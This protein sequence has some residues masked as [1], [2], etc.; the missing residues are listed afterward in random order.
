VDRALR[1]IPGLA[2]IGLALVLPGLR[3]PDGQL[4]SISWMLVVAG[5]GLAAAG[6]GYR[7]AWQQFSQLLALALVGHASALALIDAPNYEVLQHFRTWPELLSTPRGLL[8]LVPLS[9]ILLMARIVWRSWAAIRSRFQQLVSA[10]S[11]LLLIGLT[12]FAAAYGTWDVARY[13]GEVILASC[14][15]VANLAN[16][17]LVAAAIPERFLDRAAAW[18]RSRL[19]TA[20]QEKPRAVTLDRLLPWLVALGVTAVS[21]AISGLVLERT[22]HIPDSV[23]YLFQAKYFSLGKLFL[24]APPDVAA[25]EL[26]KLYTDG[27]RWWNYGFPAWPLVLSIGVRLGAAWLVNPILGGITILLTHGLLTRL[28]Q[29]PFAHAVVLLLAVSPWFLFMSASFMPH[30]LSVAWVLVGLLALHQAKTSGQA[31]WALL[32]G[33]SVGALLLN[34]PLEAVLIALALGAWILTFNH[35][36]LIARTLAGAG[37]GGLL[38]GGWIFPYNTALTGDPLVTPHQTWSDAL[39]YRGADRLGFGPD[40]GNLG[41]VNVDPFPGHGPVDVVV[42]AW[43]NLYNANI[44]LFGWSFGSLGFVGL[45]LLWRRWTRADW[46]FVVILIVI[47]AGHSVYWFSGGPDFGARYWY[48][49]LIPAVVL[50][51]RGIQEVQRRWEGGLGNPG[52]ST[53][54][55]AFVTLACAVS[56]VNFLPWRSL[57]KYHNYRGMNTALARLAANCDFGHALVFVEN[58]NPEDYASAFV[59]NPPALDLSDPIYVRDLGP[60]KRAAVAEHFPGRSIWVISGSSSAGEPLRVSA[61]PTTASGSPCLSSND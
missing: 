46:L 53:R 6:L 33:A 61:S 35:P 28:Y 2:L 50:T 12:V 47:V 32:A 29:R 31:R 38:V 60:A 26:D 52:V 48:Q 37:I 3:E 54:L 4:R 24:P 27:V 8:L 10:G 56:V 19:G 43:Q 40:V 30:P 7:T 21:A 41:W 49:I 13:A 11:M 51:A 59:L 39:W 34:R 1:L 25:F 44:E 18:V 17:I 45:F 58:T 22:P 42:N 36:G 16:L 14:I 5:I 23:G 57:G 20:Q 9:Q 15:I 55:A